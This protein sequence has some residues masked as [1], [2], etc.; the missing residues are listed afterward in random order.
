MKRATIL[1]LSAVMLMGPVS[2]ATVLAQ[3]PDLQSVTL[4]SPNKYRGERRPACLNL[5]SGRLSVY[6][7][8]DVYYGFLYA[9]DEWDWFQSAGY[10]DSRSVIKDLGALDWSASLIVPVIA[11]LPK[12]KPGEHRNV[13]IDVSGADGADGAPGQ[14]GADADGAIRQADK[15]VVEP[16]TPPLARKPKHDGVPKIDPMF[17]KARLGHLYVIHVVDDGNDFY[18]L[19]RVEEI[20]RGDNCRIS[21]KR[22]AAPEREADVRR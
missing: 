11:P 9:G 4:Y 21:W 3:Q 22:I 5:A 6:G 15:S 17:V 19:F 1:F 20:T 10:E 13:T 12:L 14:R 2:G 7:R 16:V 8:C 18:A